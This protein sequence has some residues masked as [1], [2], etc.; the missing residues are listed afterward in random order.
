MAVESQQ[1]AYLLHYKPFRDTSIIADVFT[2]SRGKM[3]VI[4]RGAR[5]ARSKTR[6]L[7]QPFRP[8]LISWTGD[9]ELKTL[10]DI[11]ESGPAHPFDNTALACAY[12]LNELL[13][14][15]LEKEHPVPEMFAHYALAL[16]QLEVPEKIEETLRRFELHLL[17]TLGVLPHFAT[18]TMDN[19]PVSADGHYHFYPARGLAVEHSAH[20]PTA[21]SFVKEPRPAD[22]GWHADGVTKDQHVEISGRGLLAL[23]TW[24]I[25]DADVL[26]EVKPLM[27]RL[28]RVHLGDRP[29]NSRE[30]F[31][32]L[33]PSTQP[34]ETDP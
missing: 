21:E 27:R 10:T 24:D 22:L 30:L 13:L 29:L 14:R 31:N 7:Y 1:A 19:Q 18:C 32:T 26:C 15:L 28:L 4:A 3:S 20:S 17:D 6:A 8:L 25:A 2:L 11:E 16:A 9:R 23:A 33:A 12:Y 34:L 5:S